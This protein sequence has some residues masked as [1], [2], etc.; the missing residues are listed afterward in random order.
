MKA[1]KTLVS[2]VKGSRVIPFRFGLVRF[3]PTLLGFAFHVKV[4][5]RQD[6][7]AM[8]HS[9]RLDNSSKEFYGIRGDECI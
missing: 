4:N 3:Y 7:Y 1:S 8:P 2:F 5:R 6:A 9:L